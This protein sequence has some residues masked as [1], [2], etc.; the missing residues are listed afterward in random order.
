[1]PPLLWASSSLIATSC[2]ALTAACRRSP[3][4]VD[5]EVYVYSL[6]A[7]SISARY[8]ASSRIAYSSP[9]AADWRMP[10]IR[11][12]ALYRSTSTSGAFL[13][14]DGTAAQLQPPWAAKRTVSSL[15]TAPRPASIRQKR[16]VSPRV[17]RRHPDALGSSFEDRTIVSREAFTAYLPALDDSAVAICDCAPSS[18][19][20]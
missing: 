10:S 3:C 2:Q 19:M 13:S 14:H 6:M 16:H 5:R 4:H 11:A 7:R 15:Q 12:D 20:P 8:R 9:A 1:L 17:T 18:A